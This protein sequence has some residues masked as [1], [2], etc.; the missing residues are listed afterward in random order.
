VTALYNTAYRI[1]KEIPWWE[2]ILL[3]KGRNAGVNHI[4]AEF[5]GDTLNIID[6]LN[7]SL[8]CEY[9]NAYDDVLTKYENKLG[10]GN[11]FEHPYPEIEK[12]Y[13]PLIKIMYEFDIYPD[14]K[15]LVEVLLKE[16]QKQ[17]ETMGCNIS[18]WEK[19]MET[20]YKG[21]KTDS[22]KTQLDIYKNNH[23]NTG[24]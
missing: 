22:D 7:R 12:K 17:I 23:D 6:F 20:W 14:D 24:L 5:M 2:T 16:Y 13:R 18:H 11:I 8:F 9:S 19:E 21:I 3:I 1:I 4:I 10:I 15:T